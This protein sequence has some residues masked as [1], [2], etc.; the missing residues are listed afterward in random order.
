MFKTNDIKNPIHF[1]SR[2]LC[3]GEKLL[4]YF[5]SPFYPNLG[6]MKLTENWNK[7]NYSE[8]HISQIDDLI[9]KMKNNPQDFDNK[10][11]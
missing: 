9:D 1:K 7:N 11:V 8:K 3:K 4:I 6:T 2:S 5:D 10:I